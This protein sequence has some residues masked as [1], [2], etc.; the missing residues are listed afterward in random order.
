MKKYFI[1]EEWYTK[2]KNT[3]FKY[4]N[5]CGSYE[6][7]IFNTLEECR[8]FCK[9]DNIT[10]YDISDDKKTIYYNWIEEREVDEDDEIIS[11]DYEGYLITDNEN[12][13][14]IYDGNTDLYEVTAD[15]FGYDDRFKV[16]EK[17]FI[18]NLDRSKFCYEYFD[19]EIRYCTLY[20]ND[21]EIMTTENTKAVVDK[22]KELGI[23]DSIIDDYMDGLKE[24]VF[25]R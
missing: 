2:E 12:D 9:K 17:L 6:K 3:V 11:D 5:S 18:N 15:I 21:E 7:E 8:E 23:Y 20:Y 1:I 16:A 13:T 25:K 4:Q 24:V 22:L 14:L 10:T 19:C